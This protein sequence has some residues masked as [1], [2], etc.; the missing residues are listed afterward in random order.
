MFVRRPVA[1]L[2]TRVRS[3]APSEEYMDTVLVAVFWTSVGLIMYGHL[4]YPLLIYTV[5]RLVHPRIVRLGRRPR[6]SVLVPVYNEARTIRAKIDNCLALEYPRE[7]LEILVG[8]DGSTDG[9]AEIIQLA[10]EAGK[11]TAAIFPRRRGKAAVL[12]D[13]VQ[14]AS[15]D[16]V[17]FSDATSMLDPPSLA[18]VVERFADSTVGCVSGVYRVVPHRPD[19]QAAQENI[20]WRYETFIRR[21]ESRLGTMLGAHGAMYAI[22]RRLFEPLDTA[23]INDD[24]MIPVNI[25]MKDYRS[26]Y[27]TR[28]VAREDAA[29]MAGFARRIRVMT[30]NYQQLFLLLKRPELWRRP[31]LVFQLISHKALRLLIPFLV[32]VAYVSSGALLAHPMYRVIFV[33]Q[34]LFFIAA[35]AGTC[36]GFRE[37][38]RA[39]VVAPYYFCM[40][41]IAALA[42]FYRVIWRKGAVAWE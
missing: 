26:I 42:G 32:L 29:E 8:S 14:R 30:G 39:A 34:T 15:G 20:Y 6:V 38:G 5:S 3:A 41:N 16:I 24:F 40:I 1:V 27:E 21:A 28:A 36:S 22:R 11:V 4:G 23:I 31:M 7:S 35:L 18:V 17:V 12:N 10:G 33:A 9:S 13:L 25:L 2:T 19:R 37:V